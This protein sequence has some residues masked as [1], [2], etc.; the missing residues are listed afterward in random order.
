LINAVVYSSGKQF[1]SQTIHL[2]QQYLGAGNGSDFESACND[3]GQHLSTACG[4]AGAPFD[5]GTAAII[6]W[7][8]ENYNNRPTWEEVQSGA[9]ED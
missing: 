8:S 2:I 5:L 4:L 7:L 3:L 1:E 9:S 6:C